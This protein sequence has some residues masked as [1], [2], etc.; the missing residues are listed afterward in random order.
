MLLTNNNVITR[1]ITIISLTL[2]MLIFTNAARPSIT[3]NGA[4]EYA[5]RLTDFIN[6]SGSDYVESEFS[7]LTWGQ[8]TNGVRVALIPG[9]PLFNGLNVTNE[10]IGIVLTNTTDTNLTFVLPEIPQQFELAVYDEHGTPVARSKQWNQLGQELLGVESPYTNDVNGH[11]YDKVRAREFLAPHE[12]DLFSSINLLDYYKIEKPGRY[13]VEYEQR[14][15]I[16]TLRSNKVLWVGFVLPKTT[17][18]IVMH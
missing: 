2:L 8:E 14:L 1:S 5:R 12:F 11:Q 13:R 10:Y 16:A 4:A 9:N 18:V 15:Q 7:K 6:N 17:N 3:G